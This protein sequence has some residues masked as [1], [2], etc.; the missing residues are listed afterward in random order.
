MRES[1]QGHVTSADFW[2][3]NKCVGPSASMR[4]CG[5]GQAEWWGLVVIVGTS[6]VVGWW[7]GLVAHSLKTL[8]KS[9][10]I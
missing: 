6:R 4:A 7:G 3:E 1:P 10:E 9:N 2:L 5:Q 8:S